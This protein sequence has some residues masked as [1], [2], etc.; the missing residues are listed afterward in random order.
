[1][2][3]TKLKTRILCSFIFFTIIITS[4]FALVGML[5]LQ[6]AED[7]ITD[8]QLDILIKNSKIES[9]E[10]VSI[11][12]NKSDIKEKFGLDS[13]PSKP[14]NYH[15][16][17]N[18]EGK[19]AIIPTG[20]FDRWD[21]WVAN[22][23]DREYRIIIPPFEHKSK[24]TWFV[25]DLTNSE[26]TESKMNSINILF[27]SL[28]GAFIIIAALSSIFA[29]RW[30]IK[31]LKTLSDSIK[32]NDTETPLNLPL[33]SN[34]ELG[35]L[36]KVISKYDEDK[37]QQIKNEQAFISDCSHEL[38]TP[39]TIINNSVGILNELPLNDERRDK[40]MARITR[41]GK[42]MQ[43][44][45]QTF[46]LIGRQRQDEL[47][48]IILHDLI[49]DTVKEIQS[50]NPHHELIVVNTV[51][52]NLTISSRRES[53]SI[54]CNNIIG[55]CFQHLQTGRL[56][57]TTTLENDL[58]R[59]SFTDNGPGFSKPTENT[60]SNIGYGIGLMLIERLCKREKWNLKLEQNVPHGV[61]ISIDLK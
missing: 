46:L 5:L 24:K 56:K 16:F 38:R 43:R 58:L 8:Q 28:L 3:N 13:V 1:M 6:D 31:P 15:F 52:K 10:G 55:N 48:K 9:L 22:P 21:M 7:I 37:F 40:V 53:I 23:R 50:L 26:Y 18:N 45:A 20:I 29:S 59:L 41:S 61:K 17:A 27:Y 12:K 4:T 19:Q 39:M 32:F 51:P 60:D 49:H 54:L 42:R 34:D 44:L 11:Y 2:I 57:I 36:A 25:V 14:G 33:Y 30:I 35:Y 47:E